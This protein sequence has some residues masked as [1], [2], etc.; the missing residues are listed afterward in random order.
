[1]TPEQ[2]E[3]KKVAN[4]WSEVRLMD[5][6][7]VE[8]LEP[9]WKEAYNRF[10]EKFNRDMEYG[11]EIAARLRDMIEPPKVQKKSKAQ[12]KRDKWAKVQAR[13]AAA[14]K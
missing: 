11:E 1:M 3:I 10:Y 12:K 13:Q 14:A 5:A 9:E 7:Q 2:M 6:D 8:S 4:K